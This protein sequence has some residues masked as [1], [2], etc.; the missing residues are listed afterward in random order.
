LQIAEIFRGSLSHLL[1]IGSPRDTYRQGVLQEEELALLNG[2]QSEVR[3]DEEM[4]NN[5]HDKPDLASCDSCG[6]ILACDAIAVE[7]ESADPGGGQEAVLRVFRICGLTD[8][9]NGASLNSVRRIDL[10]LLVLSAGRF[11]TS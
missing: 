7:E 6:A 10:Q 1:S 2:A 3:P 5:R 8:D 4:L 9:Q 11:A